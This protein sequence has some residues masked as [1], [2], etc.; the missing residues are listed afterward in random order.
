LTALSFSA[1]T[2]Q[3]VCLSFP[4][5]AQATDLDGQVTN[6]QFLLNST[7]LASFT[8]PPY[9]I[10]VTYDFP[11]NATLT[12]RAYDDKGGLRQTNV[13]VNFF[14]L[15]LHVVNLG[16]ILSNGGFKFCMLG[17]AGK[18]YGVQANTNLNT[19][20]WIEIGTMESTNGVWRFV[21]TNAPIINRRYYRAR[22]L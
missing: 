5:S 17:Q 15:P 8:N 16:G 3:L 20:N 22:Q 14:T 12:A 9:A 13:A 11:G 2:S 21:D 4:L 10:D 7:V 18:D 1:P 6:V 19:T